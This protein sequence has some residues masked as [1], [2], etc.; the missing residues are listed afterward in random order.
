MIT[1]LS[2]LKVPLPLFVLLTVVNQQH[3]VGFSSPHTHL[4]VLLCPTNYVCKV[5]CSYLFSDVHT[6]NPQGL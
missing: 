4:Y 3:I 5:S 6:A 1:T 2:H